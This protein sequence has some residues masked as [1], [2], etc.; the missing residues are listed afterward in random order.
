MLCVAGGVLEEVGLRGVSVS[1]SMPGRATLSA[2]S[3]WVMDLAVEGP[4]GQ[5]L[6]KVFRF[7]IKPGGSS[8]HCSQ[9][10]CENGVIPRPTDSETPG[11]KRADRDDR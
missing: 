3:V 5:A 2:V 10:R 1:P 6:P 9:A 7:P 4:R 8:I 11:Q